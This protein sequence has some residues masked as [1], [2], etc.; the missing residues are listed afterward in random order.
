M[1]FPADLVEHRL[2]RLDLTKV[3][4]NHHAGL[5]G[6]EIVWGEP[7]GCDR[8]ACGRNG[9]GPSQVFVVGRRLR[10]PRLSALLDA[11]SGCIESGER[12]DAGSALAD[13]LPEGIDVAADTCPFPPSIRI[14][15]GAGSDS[16]ATR[17]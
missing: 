2:R 8:F 6:F 12:S 11:V 13:R 7:S 10:I 9:K 17:V 16:F 15:S 1:L 3:R 14:R 4:C 5:G